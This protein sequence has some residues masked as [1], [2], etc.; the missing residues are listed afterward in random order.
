MHSGGDARPLDACYNI[1]MV[2]DSK[3][4][5][6]LDFDVS[7]CP[8][9]S[10]AL[11][12]MT[13]S[14]KEIMGVDTISAT[15]DKGY[16][17]GKDIADCEQSGTTCYV[18]KT[19]DYSHAP[20]K[21]YDKSN[22]RYDAENDR[23]ICPENQ[24]PT[25]KKTRPDGSRDYQNRKAC[26][27]CVNR[28]K[29]TESKTGRTVSRAVNQSVLDAMNARMR[30][31]EGRKILRQRKKIIEHP[32]GTTKAVWGFKQFLCRTRERVVGEQSLTFLA[33]NL[34]RVINIFNENSWDL[35]AAMA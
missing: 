8:D 25:C 34:R 4:N 20:D 17:D 28:E 5:L 35:M 33:Y 32:F 13:D 3:H 19:A 18:P 9:D 2:A 15:A 1:Q 24:A 7:T 23:Y 16:Y 27:T 12:Q 11:H 29:C 22:F 31:C 10:G 26:E 21:N 14:A 6:L 30:T